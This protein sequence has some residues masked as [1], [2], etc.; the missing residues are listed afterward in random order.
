MSSSS[1]PD[2]YEPLQKLASGL[3]P[4]LVDGDSNPISVYEGPVEL[5][6]DRQVFSGNDAISMRRHV[7]SD[8]PRLTQ[9]ISRIVEPPTEY[10]R[11]GHRRVTVLLHREGW[12]VNHKRVERNWR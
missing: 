1:P 8:E 7:P 3:Q 6:E 9:L 12:Q 10:G 4:V 5:T 11:Y 2:A